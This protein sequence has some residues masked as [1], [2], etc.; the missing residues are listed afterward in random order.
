M[1]LS[2]KEIKERI[3]KNPHSVE[4]IYD[5][6]CRC[7]LMYDFNDVQDF[8]SGV[9]IARFSIPREKLIELMFDHGYIPEPW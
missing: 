8:L 5:P 3:R 6:Q 4:V 2:I 1:N 7:L 9:G